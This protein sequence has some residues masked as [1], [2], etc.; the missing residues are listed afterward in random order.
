MR[1]SLHRATKPKECDLCGTA[2]PVRKL[3]DY[4]EYWRAK[5]GQRHGPKVICCVCHVLYG[6]PTHGW[7]VHADGHDVMSASVPS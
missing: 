4:A 1:F 6:F 5:G 7:E 3:P 2:I